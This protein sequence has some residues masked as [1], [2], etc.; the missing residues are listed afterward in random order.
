MD[1][2]FVY[3][4]VAATADGKIDTFERRGAVISSARDK[5][6]VD[7][8]RAESDAVLIGGRTLHGDDPKLTI[9]SAVLRAEREALGLSANP[10][11]VAIASR[12][13]LKINSNFLTAG[14]SRMMLFT[15]SQTP[16]SQ[17]GMLRSSGA[18]VYVLGNEHVDLV[19]VLHILKE[20][21]IKKLIV[22][23]GATLNFE[24]INLGLVDKLTIY[25]APM[26]FG[27]ERAP[28]LAAGLGRVRSAAIPLKLI[29]SE[30]WE[31]GGVLLTYR[32][33]QEV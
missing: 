28:T 5:E 31:D 13:E 6:R 29:E 18:E 19:N 16:E 4:N 30:E 23:G 3:V 11:K 8:L 2:P 26:I 12:L 14:P 7:K 27:G 33:S 32:L 10:I 24:L 21:E 22:E 15:T 17:L 20:N 1:R 25:I 9:K